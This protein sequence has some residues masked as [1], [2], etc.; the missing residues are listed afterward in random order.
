MV[1]GDQ[2]DVAV[3]DGA[4]QRLDLLAFADRRRALRH[5]PDRDSVLL[6]ERKIVRAGLAGDVDALCSRLGDEPHARGARDVDDVQGT[7]GFLR[8]LE[9]SADRTELGHDRPRV[10]VVAERDASLRNRPRRE[11]RRQLR[12]LGVHCDGEPELC[13]TRHPRA[14]CLVVRHHKVV[15]AGRT[16]ERL[17][18]DDAAIGELVEAVYRPGHEPSPEGEVDDRSLVCGGKLE[19]EGRAVDRRR[20]RIQRH[21]DERRRPSR[22]QR[23]GRVGKSLPVAAAGIVAMHVR[24]DNPGEDV[25]TGR[26]DRLRGRPAQLGLDCR[27]EAVHDADIAHTGPRRRDDR[28]TANNEIEPAQGRSIPW[29]S[30]R[31]A[32]H[33]NTPIVRA[34]GHGSWH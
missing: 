10:E 24:V 31:S 2:I 12:V 32:M 27:D 23:A 7:P 11:P 26:V 34:A 13:G 17:E 16:H 18:A 5:H 8:Q 1:R 3:K 14:E 20:A 21:V 30:V 25:E 9:R 19:V 28:S 15:D 29:R 22:C 6:V 33:G 4:P